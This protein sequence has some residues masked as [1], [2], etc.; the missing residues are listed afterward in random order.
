MQI[1]PISNTATEF[2]VFPG[3][4]FEPRKGVE[5][6]AVEAIEYGR[7]LGLPEHQVDWV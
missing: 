3:K 4:V 5:E 7:A 6:D 1:S 2:V